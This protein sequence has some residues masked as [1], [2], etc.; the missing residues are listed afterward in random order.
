MSSDSPRHGYVAARMVRESPEDYDAL[1]EDTSLHAL[2]DQLH[3]MQM[4]DSW[5]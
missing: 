3:E 5:P 1:Q 2:Q 4:Q